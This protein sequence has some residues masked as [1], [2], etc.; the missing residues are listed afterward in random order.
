MAT[1]TLFSTARTVQ[2]SVPALTPEDVASL[3]DMGMLL[4]GDLAWLTRVLSD[5]NWR[6][7][8]E[9]KDLFR[10][11]PREPLAALNKRRRAARAFL[12]GLFQGRVADGYCRDLKN[13]WLPELLGRNKWGE[14]DRELALSFLEYTMG[15]LVG[16]LHFEPREN[17]VPLA[18]IQL[19][20]EH[21]F[22]RMLFA[23]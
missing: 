22:Q 4:D 6:P 12:V 11:P 1:G 19:A 18:R 14:T 10:R 21:A 8:S 3:K 20:L 13:V 9:R 15:L 7:L 16:A 5:R 23:I 2:V 17:L